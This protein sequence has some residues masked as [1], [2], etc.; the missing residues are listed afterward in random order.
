MANKAKEWTCTGIFNETN[1]FV[2]ETRLECETLRNMLRDYNICDIV[3]NIDIIY[4]NI[5]I[6]HSHATTVCFQWS[7]Q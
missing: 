3:Y 2:S 7:A 5:D 1:G 4:T 6:Q